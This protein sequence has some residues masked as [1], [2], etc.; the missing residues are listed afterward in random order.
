MQTLI[1]LHPYDM[2]KSQNPY[3][4]KSF[5]NVGMDSDYLQ[6]SKKYFFYSTLK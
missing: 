3:M 6:M 1:K 4:L 2:T 5:I